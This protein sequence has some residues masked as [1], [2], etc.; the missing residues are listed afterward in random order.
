MQNPTGAAYLRRG[1]ALP[2]NPRARWVTEGFQRPL[3]SNP[4][5]TL[6]L[7]TGTSSRTSRRPAFSAAWQMGRWAG[8]AIAPL[9]VPPARPLACRRVA[10]SLLAALRC[11][12]APVAPRRAQARAGARPPPR[13]AGGAAAAARTRKRD[14][15]Q[16]PLLPAPR[17]LRAGPLAAGGAVARGAAG[18]L[19]ARAAGAGSRAGVRDVGA[20]R[21]RR[22]RAGERRCARCARVSP[23]PWRAPAALSAA[24][25]LQVPALDLCEPL[26]ARLVAW[27]PRFRLS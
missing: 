9:F 14:A 19:A 27:V 12:V 10:A 4:G 15:R 23:Q 24:A 5:S 22:A 3:P 16:P 1:A 25:L 13:G 17:A 8:E 20:P 26:A 2:S 7:L 18:E 6:L 21:G 11:A